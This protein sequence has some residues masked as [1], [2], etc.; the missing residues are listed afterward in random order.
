MNIC[1]ATGA[2]IFPSHRAANAAVRAQARRRRHTRR[3]N[4]YVCHDCGGHHVG[5]ERRRRPMRRAA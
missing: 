4:I 5:H 1:L 3:P 2:E